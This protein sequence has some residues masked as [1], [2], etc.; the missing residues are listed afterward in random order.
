[1]LLD[2]SKG[3]AVRHIAIHQLY[4]RQVH[5]E[6]M[7][8]FQTSCTTQILL[9]QRVAVVC[10]ASS[11]ATRT[12]AEAGCHINHQHSVALEGLAKLFVSDLVRPDPNE[13]GLDKLLI[14]LKVCFAFVARVS[15]ELS[16]INLDAHIVTTSVLD[17]HWISDAR[18]KASFTINF[19]C[20]HGD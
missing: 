1:M 20:F 12:E 4:H 15:V 16:L 9:A 8:A 3:D 18:D 10:K 6:Q 2:V 17:E 11:V 5:L 7:C 19:K 14:E 13:H